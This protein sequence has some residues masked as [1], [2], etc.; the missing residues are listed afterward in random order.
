MSKSLGNSLLV[1]D[2]LSRV[3]PAEL[4]YYLVQAHYRSPLE[5]S[6]DALEEAVAAYQRIERFVVRAS[7]ALGRLG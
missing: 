5:Y 7:E 2:V 4:R 1:T 3:R 6:E